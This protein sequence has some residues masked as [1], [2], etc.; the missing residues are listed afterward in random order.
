MASVKCS[1][2]VSSVK[3]M[4]NLFDRLREYRNSSENNL[5]MYLMSPQERESLKMGVFDPQ[6]IYFI[7]ESFGYNYTKDSWHENYYYIK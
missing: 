4:T 5:F 7:D 6:S 3:N 1:Q 2:Y